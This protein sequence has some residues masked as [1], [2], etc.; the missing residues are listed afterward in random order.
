[1]RKLG[2]IDAHDVREFRFSE[3][4]VTWEQI[5]VIVKWFVEVYGS[6]K[7]DVPAYI[8]P[9]MKSDSYDLDELRIRMERFE[10]LLKQSIKEE[11]SKQELASTAD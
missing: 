5:H 9:K 1:M 4:L 6:H 10:E 7:I 8:D 11:T 3:S 2:N